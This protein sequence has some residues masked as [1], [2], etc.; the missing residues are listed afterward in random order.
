MADEIGELDR[1]MQLANDSL[2]AIKQQPGVSGVAAKASATKRDPGVVNVSEL[3]SQ[4]RRNA[5]AQLYD[6]PVSITPKSTGHDYPPTE[7]RHERRQASKSMAQQPSPDHAVP[8]QARG[9]QGSRE[10][11]RTHRQ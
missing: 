4:D 8:A 5:Q 10:R 7:Q 3:L 11:S 1:L 2:S 9:R 6:D